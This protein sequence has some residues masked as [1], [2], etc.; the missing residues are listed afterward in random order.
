MAEAR[1]HT[2]VP[3]EDYWKKN[4]PC[5]S[6]CPVETDAR[7]YN[8]SIAQGDF[9]GAFR[10]AR[11]SNPLAIICARICG[12]PCEEVCRR[13]TLDQ[14]VAIRALKL[15]SYENLHNEMAS[16]S[17]ATPGAYQTFGKSGLVCSGDYGELR[18]AIENGE[19]PRVVGKSIGIVGSG[20]SGL[21]AA[22]DL[23]L[24]GCKVTIYERETV[25]AG[26][27]YLGIP[28]YRLP[29]ALIKVEVE[30][31]RNLG[32]DIKTNCAVG[33][34]VTLAELRRRHD[35]VIIACGLKKSRA[36]PLVGAEALGVIGGIEFLREVALDEPH[37]IGNRIVV[38]GGG[39]V[40]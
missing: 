38:L 14:S 19:I 10:I 29:T 32:V 13:G 17:E 21:A 28:S 37:V 1:Y 23:T 9:G 4:I 11:A 25:P 18:Q 40:A 22:H 36:L 5:L 16:D 12:A 3:D 27:L 20:P 31:I 35:A 7:G 15:A 34:D 30:A 24:M 2:I 8:R 39:N 33:E 26:M 6:A